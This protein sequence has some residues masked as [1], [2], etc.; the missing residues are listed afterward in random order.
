[1]YPKR[2]ELKIWGVFEGANVS[3]MVWIEDLGCFRR[4]KCIPNG[5]F[6]WFGMYVP[7]NIS[8]GPVLG[9]LRYFYTLSVSQMGV[10]FGFY[11]I[12]CFKDNQNPTVR[13]RPSQGR[14]SCR[15]WGRHHTSRFCWL[16]NVLLSIITSIE[17]QRQRRKL[18][19]CGLVI[20]ADKEASTYGFL[21]QLRFSK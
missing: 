1:M 4:G 19:F 16:S 6:L 5:L 18:R 14:L 7:S 11:D 17:E 12:N 21:S 20:Q 10:F 8:N 2:S 13:Y 3:Q 9:N 15:L